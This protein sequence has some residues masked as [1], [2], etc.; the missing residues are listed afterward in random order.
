MSTSTTEPKHVHDNEGHCQNC[1]DNGYH[2]GRAMLVSELRKICASNHHPNC[3]CE[4]CSFLRREDEM[5]TAR[6]MERRACELADLL[7]ESGIELPRWARSEAWTRR[8]NLNR[9]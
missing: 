3:V 7:E 1:F 5:L 6:V 4:I 8:R 2:D 9:I